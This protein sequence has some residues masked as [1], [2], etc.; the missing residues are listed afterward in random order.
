[1]SAKRILSSIF[2]NY[3]G[4]ITVSLTGFVAT[5]IIVHH[6]GKE[7]FGAW[8]LI[9]AMIG[10]SSLLDLGVGLTV[11][12]LVAEKAHLNDRR[13][14]NDI[15]NTA[16]ALLSF[17]GIVC[18][19]VGFLLLS[20]LGHV[21]HVSPG[22]ESQ[23]RVAVV[24]VFA[25]VGFTFPS[26]LYTGVNQGFGHFRQQNVIVVIQT[27]AGTTALVVVVVA[28]GGLIPIALVYMV[29]AVLGFV[30]KVVYAN[31]AYVLRANPFRFSRKLAPGLI[32]V[33]VWMFVI[34]LTSKIIWNTDTIVVGAVLG[35][36]AVAHYAVALGPAAAVRTIT[37]QFN[38]VTYAAA[39]TLRAKDEVSGL[40]RLLLEATRVVVSCTGPFVILFMLWGSAFLRLWVGPSFAAS[41]TT[42]VILVVGMLSASVQ[43]TATQI[44]LAFHK[45]RSMAVVAILEALANL[46]CSIYLAHR[47]GIEGVALGTTVP[48]TI[49]AFGYYVPR[50]ASLLD[51]PVVE[52][53][54]RL[55]APLSL[56][57]GTYCVMRFVLPPLVFSSL[58]EFCAFAVVFAGGL[59]LVAILLNR[60]ERGTYL[61]VIRSL[62][63]SRSAA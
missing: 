29:S 62:T 9:V 26:G 35:T 40:R 61:N 24:L 25:T 6:L 14:V 33:S 8:S 50:A 38:S 22:L 49:T 34:Q 28:G 21:F 16:L 41:S 60:D 30:A 57:I 2:F 47:M 45:Q 15:V 42:L 43:A 44:L 23:F 19:A 5:P 27:L 1:M 20:R 52:I 17:A 55:V 7:G 59:G 12:R 11:M 36:V 3:L 18:V 58:I 46:S 39:A 32:S 53:L 48:T 54:K 10:Y 31:C 63:P 51:V 4:A 13:E 37:D 56:F